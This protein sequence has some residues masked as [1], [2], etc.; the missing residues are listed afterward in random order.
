MGQFNE[1][2]IDF[3]G[4]ELFAGKLVVF[5]GAGA[6]IDSELPSWSGLVNEFAKKQGKQKKN[7]TSEELLVIPEAYYKK[8]GKIPYYKVLN[9]VFS[10]EYQPNSIHKELAKLEVNYLITTNFDSLIEDEVNKSYDYDV[11]KKDE[12]LAHSIR[13]KMIIKMHGDF[14]NKNIILKKS[15]FKNYEEYFPLVSTFI[16]GLFTTN[17]ILFIGYSLND[18][19]VKKII[20]WIKEILNEDFRRV[21]LVEYESNE[22][23]LENEEDEMINRIV[24]PNVVEGKG[25]L[26]ANL[27]KNI[28]E[29]KE[30]LKKEENFSI[31]SNLEYLSE[32]NVKN[33]LKDFFYLLVTM[34][35]F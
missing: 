4:E 19:N 20:S 24:L 33:Q 22:I 34:M 1:Q 28:N 11:I 3:L 10:K 12:D 13:N 32:A 15:D 29:R 6:S 27:L 5:V 7:F 30:E 17:T 16:K 9:D 18:P 2:Y 23:R 35:I 21:Y 8:F 31:Y 26:L 14:E 25:E